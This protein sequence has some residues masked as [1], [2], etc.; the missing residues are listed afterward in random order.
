MFFFFYGFVGR[1]GVSGRSEGGR[2]FWVI[3]VV[4]NYCSRIV[5]VKFFK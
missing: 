1:Y 4:V 2:N 5:K 3:F